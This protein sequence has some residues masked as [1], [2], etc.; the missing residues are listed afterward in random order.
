[1]PRY[2]CRDS[3]LS[4]IAESIRDGLVVDLEPRVPGLSDVW[5]LGVVLCVKVPRDHTIGWWL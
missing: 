2:V 5:V 3:Y 1:M 4:Y